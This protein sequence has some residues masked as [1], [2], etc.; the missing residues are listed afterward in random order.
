MQINEVQFNCEL[1]DILAELKKQLLLNQIPLL[2]KIKDSGNDIMV[3][4]PYHNNGQE[5]RPSAGISKKDG[6]FHCFTCNEVHGLPEV[7][8]YCFGR[9]D[10]GVFGWSWLLKNFISIEV[11]E[12]KDV[13]LDLERSKSVSRNCGI[14]T[15][16]N[17][18][19]SNN[20]DNLRRHISVE[21]LDSYRY[22]HPYMYKRKLTNEI[23]EL[24]DIGYDKKT[25][26]ITF[27]IRDVNGNV[28]AIARRSV[29][30]K[31][32][33]YPSGFEKPVYGLYEIAQCNN[34][35][36]D[37]VIICESM[38]DALTCWVYGKPAVALN[39]LGTELQFKQL[40][41]LPYRKY[42]LATDSDEA[43]MNARKRI[44]KNLAGKIITE[45]L[46]PEGRK[47]INELSKEEFD[48]LEEVF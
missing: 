19:S 29:K 27:P 4:C 18:D 13:K 41:S 32:F 47:D 43:G 34:L 24:F 28:L 35:G 11:E 30:G 16:R 15:S 46:L 12:R 8:S 39:G 5:K 45:Y 44:R 31:Y 17:D 48:D 10:Y 20:Q 26:C 2:N 25:D 9:D 22:Y 33:N 23:I 37:E 1:S 36:Q 6:I 21:E 14:I 42:I 38:L 3:S 7:I 40:K